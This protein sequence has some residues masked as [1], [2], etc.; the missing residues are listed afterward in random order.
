MAGG[1]CVGS[2]RKERVRRLERSSYGNSVEGY[3]KIDRSG[4]TTERSEATE[5]KATWEGRWF[6]NSAQRN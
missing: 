6:R 1:T 5:D 3:G 4:P 2:F